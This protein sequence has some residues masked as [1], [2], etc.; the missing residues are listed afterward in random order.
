MSELSINIKI[1]GR[2]YPLMV[3]PEAEVKVR[4][5]AKLIQ[6]KL[7]SYK[8]GYSVKDNQDV[9][10]MFAIELATD[11]LNLR[12]QIIEENASN[13]KALQQ[14]LSELKSVQP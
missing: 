9:L 11:Y 8:S 1:A 6:D 14:I 10:A 3:K 12:D 5:A 2:T 13:E 4:A 7:D